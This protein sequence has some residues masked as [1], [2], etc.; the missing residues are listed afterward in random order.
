MNYLTTQETIETLTMERE[1]RYNVVEYQCEY[2]GRIWD[3]NAQC[4]CIESYELPDPFPDTISI[5]ESESLDTNAIAKDEDEYETDLEYS[6][7]E[8][9]DYI[10]DIVSYI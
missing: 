5:S 3:G 7:D 1:D 10:V 4:Q 2:C 9:H 6:S 8:E